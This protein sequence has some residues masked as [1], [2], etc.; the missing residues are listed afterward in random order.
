MRYV[1]LHLHAKC[2]KYR[3]F[4]FKIF[5]WFHTICHPCMSQQSFW[6][7]LQHR[8]KTYAREC[9]LEAHSMFEGKKLMTI[10]KPLTST[11]ALTRSN[12]SSTSL[13]SRGTASM[14][15]L[16]NVVIKTQ[17]CCWASWYKTNLSA[18]KVFS[19]FQINSM[20]FTIQIVLWYTLKGIF[21]RKDWL[22]ESILPY[23][24]KYSGV[25]K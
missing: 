20:L 14:I 2:H 15:I 17:V 1:P 24:W 6:Q 11:P 19:V 16:R 7:Y 21:S 3:S 12:L 9:P 8:F 23:F 5:A 22:Y 4:L 18:F 10:H 25:I 13:V